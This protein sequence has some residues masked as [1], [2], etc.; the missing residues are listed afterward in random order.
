VSVPFQIVGPDGKPINVTP[1][2]TIGV[3]VHDHPPTGETIQ[4]PLWHADFETAAGSADMVVVG[5]TA[6]PVDFC[7]SALPTA[8]RWVRSMSFEVSDRSCAL[9]LWGAL[10]ALTNGVQVLWIT[11]DLG[12]VELFNWKTNFQATQAQGGRAGPGSGLAIQ[13]ES[14]QTP[15]PTMRTPCPWR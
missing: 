15:W 7:V 1:E 4:A 10:A 11:Q 6:A 5:T 14:R 3:V 8:D 2:G 9:Y 13:Q 12:E